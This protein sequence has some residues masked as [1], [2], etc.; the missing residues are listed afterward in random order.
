[1]IGPDVSVNPVVLHASVA[2]NRV[3]SLVAGIRITLHA[4]RKQYSA[5]AAKHGDLREGQHGALV[6]AVQSEGR[7]DP[8]P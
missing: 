8:G 2:L 4:G 6:A 7:G 5:A 1:M 3:D